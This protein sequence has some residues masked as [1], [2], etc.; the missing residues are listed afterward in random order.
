MMMMMMMTLV[1]SFITLLWMAN[2]AY[3]PMDH[4]IPL[5]LDQRQSFQQQQ[6]QQ[7]PIFDEPMTP[8]IAWLEYL[9]HV[10][11]E[12]YNYSRAQQCIDEIRRLSGIS[13]A[14]ASLARLAIDG[15]ARRMRGL[16]RSPP[17]SNMLKNL[18]RSIRNKF[19]SKSKGRG[20]GKT[21]STAANAQRYSDYMQRLLAGDTGMWEQSHPPPGMMSRADGYYHQ[22]TPF[23]PGP[24]FG[25]D[26][27]QAAMMRRMIDCPNCPQY[28]DPFNPYG[29]GQVHPLS[30][31]YNHRSPITP[32]PISSSHRTNQV[33]KK[34]KMTR[35][36][37]TDKI[38]AMLFQGK[39]QEANVLFSRLIQNSTSSKRPI[40]R[41][42]LVL[43]LIDLDLT[44]PNDCVPLW[45]ANWR[46]HWRDKLRIVDVYRSCH[47][48]SYLYDA[49]FATI[50][51][52]RFKE[53]I[54]AR[55]K[56]ILGAPDAMNLFSRVS[57]KPDFY[58]CATCWARKRMGDNGMDRMRRLL[59]RAE[60]DA[61]LTPPYRRHF[62]QLLQ[63][64]FQPDRF[65]PRVSYFQ[66]VFPKDM[67]FSVITGEYSGLYVYD[68]GSGSASPYSSYF[69]RRW[70]NASNGKS[71][72]PLR[73]PHSIPRDRQE[74]LLDA[75]ADGSPET[76]A[77][78]MNTHK[79]KLVKGLLRNNP[80]IAMNDMFQQVDQLERTQ[81]RRKA[82]KLSK[83][84]IKKDE[85]RKKE[86]EKAINE[87]RVSQEQIDRYNQV[88][89]ANQELIAK[90]NE[91]LVKLQELLGRAL[92]AESPIPG[93]DRFGM[94]FHDFGTQP[95]SRRDHKRLIKKI[96]RARKKLEKL[97]KKSFHDGLSNEHQ[98][99][100]REQ[101][102]YLD[103]VAA[104]Q[105]AMQLLQ[106]Q[107]EQV[108]QYMPTYYRE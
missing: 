10:Y 1:V 72:R 59:V 23:Q 19:K 24:S 45:D 102:E 54:E 56:T 57:T 46:L 29:S 64:S 9:G 17:R 67:A 87:G 105:N 94:S 14:D 66:A 99:A 3:Y 86:W 11:I 106:Q 90:R 61:D 60:H 108:E 48:S 31:L 32:F 42:E 44:D 84:Q 39:V 33:Y 73:N 101:T 43:S 18:S 50:R 55:I 25:M 27:S 65:D 82:K 83:K 62:A 20:R 41:I 35:M 12:V 22:G 70:H 2:A 104:T 16:Q 77:R 98:K 107:L 85:K 53:Q 40:Y 8:R 80:H 76:L 71:Y 5:T 4:T 58:A 21:R 49:L 28:N 36:K 15:M 6:Q 75:F 69:G 37:K 38:H 103:K 96:E 100:Y 93:R 79:H 51:K 63:Q 34:P 92:K 74:V 97:H 81:K 88:E 26:T 13:L 95:L 30:N 47:R 7:Q 78:L 91:L 68:Q 89:Q 52:L